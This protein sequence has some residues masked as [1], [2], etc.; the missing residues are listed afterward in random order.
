MGAVGYLWFSNTCLLRMTIERAVVWS[1][2]HILNGLHGCFEVVSEKVY[3]E[4]IVVG[5]V[6]RI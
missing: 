3:I 6:I 5:G 4:V 1:Y 2:L